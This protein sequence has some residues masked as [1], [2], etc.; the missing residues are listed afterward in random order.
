MNL[1]A[2]LCVYRA[3]PRRVWTNCFAAAIVFNNFPEA[4]L[5]NTLIAGSHWIWDRLD[6]IAAVFLIPWGLFLVSLRLVGWKRFTQSCGAD[7]YLIL[8]TLDLDF[9]L[10]KERFI[11]FVYTG[12]QPKFMPIFAIGFMISLF[13]LVLS[14]TAQRPI[15]GP[16][17]RN[18][19]GSSSFLCWMF[20]P[21]WTAAHF[22][23]ILV[24]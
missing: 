7:I 6:V 9:V 12:I 23:A 16:G 1:S 18:L 21:F 20:A 3:R 22:L 11:V 15:D 8:S 19:P 24:R 4:K 2:I 5:T 14:S 17:S 13:F 10:F